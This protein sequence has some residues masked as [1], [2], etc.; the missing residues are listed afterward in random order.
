M[1]NRADINQA[2][3][4][5]KLQQSGLSDDQQ[6]LQIGKWLIAN[7][8]I[9]GSLGVIGSSLILQSRMTDLQTM[10]TISH[11]SIRAGIGKEEEL[12]DLIPLLARKLC[13]Q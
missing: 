6:A 11:G 4:E 10:K 5:F 1:I 12:L 9:S 2:L 13:G 8:T 7:R 3:Q